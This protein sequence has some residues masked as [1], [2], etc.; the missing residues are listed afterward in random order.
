MKSTAAVVARARALVVLL[1]TLAPCVAQEFSWVDPD[2][3]ERTSRDRRAV[4]PS[5][6]RGVTAKTTGRRAL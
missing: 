5:A 4:P 3:R 2:G 6:W 1:L